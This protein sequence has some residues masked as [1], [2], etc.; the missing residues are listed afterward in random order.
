MNRWFL[1]SAPLLLN[2]MLFAQTATTSSKP[3]VDQTTAT[4]TKP[5]LDQVAT[6]Q[7]KALV[8]QATPPAATPVIAQAADVQFEEKREENDMEALR[9]WLQDKRFVSLKEIGGDLSISGEVRTEA[10]YTNETKKA[11]IG[12]AHV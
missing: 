10:Q 8:V 1:L 11:Q 6:I 3:L 4:P 9:R 2:A 7:P 5:S 12:R